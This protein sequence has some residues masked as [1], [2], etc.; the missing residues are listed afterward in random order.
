MVS[1]IS[2]GFLGTDDQRGVFFCETDLET[3][4][5]CDEIIN[6]NYAMR[7]I[8]FEHAQSGGLPLRK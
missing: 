1:Q 8:R 4:F 3:R 6:I 2:W 7:R 5:A